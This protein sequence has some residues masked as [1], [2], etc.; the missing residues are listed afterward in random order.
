MASVKEYQNLLESAKR[1]Q[2]DN[3]QVDQSL[4]EIANKIINNCTINNIDDVFLCFSAFNYLNFAT[5]KEKSIGY[6]FKNKIYDIVY[7]TL[8]NGIK[9]V[10]FYY[11]ASGI[12][13]VKFHSFIFS[14]H[15]VNMRNLSDYLMRLPRIT[16]DNIRKQPCADPILRAALT[17]SNIVYNN[18]V[19][20]NYNNNNNNYNYQNNSY[21]QSN[22]LSN[23]YH[24]MTYSYRPYTVEQ[25]IDVYHIRKFVT[26]TEAA[27]NIGT[28][29]C[30]LYYTFDLVCNSNPPLPV[31]MAK[32]FYHE[33]IVYSYSI[34]EAIE[35]EI[36]AKKLGIVRNWY[37]HD[38]D[39]DERCAK[40]F[41]KYVNIPT[42]IER[43]FEA[44]RNLRNNV[45]LSKFQNILGQK[46]Y[47]LKDVNEMVTLM[48]EYIEYLNKVIK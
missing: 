9:N 17:K 1:H 16:F 12:L 36:G 41:N 2:N 24:N 5:K 11:E 3:Y 26:T 37:Q 15:S 45:H 21:S 43:K 10:E 33:I 48:A 6:T 23:N 13:Y 39:K 47:N 32:R 29:L 35:F 25:M 4:V 30:G 42:N 46:E 22:T 18:K 44:Y 31:H 20:N 34:I 7:K 28:V 27:Q 38:R 40:E 14:F 8:N 19:N